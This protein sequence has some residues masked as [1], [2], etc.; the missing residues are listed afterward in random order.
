[1]HWW[2]SAAYFVTVVRE[3]SAGH[4]RTLVIKPTKYEWKRFMDHAVRNIFCS[5]VV[6]TGNTGSTE[7]GV[8]K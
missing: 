8:S 5:Y 2:N 4:A 6:Q 1:M 7:V 3:M